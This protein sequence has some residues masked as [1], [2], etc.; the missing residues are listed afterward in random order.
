MLITTRS[1][2]RGARAALDLELPVLAICRG[3]QV[4][5]VALGGTLHQHI[6]DGETTVAAPA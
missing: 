3:C 6:T 5:N 4:L 2:C 1:S